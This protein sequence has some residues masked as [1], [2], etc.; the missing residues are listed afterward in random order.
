[1]K[2]RFLRYVKF[3][4]RSDEKSETIPSTPSQME[5]AK[6]LKKELEDLGLSNVFINKACF[7]NATLP[8]NMDKKVATIGFIAHMDTADFNAEGINPQIIENYDGS[9]IVLNKEQNDDVDLK[10]I[11][12]MAKTDP[13]P[14]V[15]F[16]EITD[17]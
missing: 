14:E 1:L 16:A 7:V 5:F 13:L 11:L 8:S 10:R 12:E 4:T 6:M 15:R 3:N 17:I 9:D 2:E